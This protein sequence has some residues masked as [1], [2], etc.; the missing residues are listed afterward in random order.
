MGKGKVP[1]GTN[2]RETRVTKLEAREEGTNGTNLLQG[3]NVNEK[4]DVQTAVYSSEPNQKGRNKILSKNQRSQSNEAHGNLENILICQSLCICICS[5]CF[6]S[7]FVCMC[8]R[9]TVG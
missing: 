7:L 6:L 4:E 8:T 3:T 9:Q 1:Q 5:S 2:A